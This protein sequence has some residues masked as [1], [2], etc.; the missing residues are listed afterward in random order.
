[1][2]LPGREGQGMDTVKQTN[3][4][5]NKPQNPK[6]TKTPKLN[7]MKPHQEYITQPNI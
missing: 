5:K 2:K 3:K 4:Q 1:M 6:K 7:E